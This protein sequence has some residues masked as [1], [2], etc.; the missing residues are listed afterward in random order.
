[1]QLSSFS[2]ASQGFLRKQIVDRQ[3]HTRFVFTVSN[4]GKIIAK[5]KEFCKPV[6]LRPLSDISTVK[7]ISGILKREKIGM[8]LN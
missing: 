8:L 4:P 5:I 3:E 2:A 6:V 7:L 1:M